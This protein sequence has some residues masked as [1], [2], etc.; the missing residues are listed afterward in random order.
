[1][2]ASPENPNVK[3]ESHEGE[4][5]FP[6]PD[7]S[8]ILYKLSGKSSPPQTLQTLDF[9]L[10]AKKSA[11]LSIPIKNWLKTSQRFDVSWKFDVEDKF[12]FINAATTFDIVG[13]STKEFK[14]SIYALKACQSKFEV[15]FKNPLTQEYL[16]YKVNLTAQPPE[17]MA[18]TELVSLVR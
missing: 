5:F 1:M 4:L 18:K 16:S 3:E 15:V 2:T 13:D 14:L 7:G 8:A 6:I 10:K 9:T 11:F 17:P 12:V